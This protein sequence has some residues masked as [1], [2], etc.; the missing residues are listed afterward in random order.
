GSRPTARRSTYTDT[1]WTVASFAA[2]RRGAARQW[3]RGVPPS[4]RRQDDRRRRGASG[5]AGWRSP[6]SVAAMAD[7]R[8]DLRCD[9]RPEAARNQL[10]DR[11]RS[12]YGDHLPAAAGGLLDHRPV[13]RDHRQACQVGAR[14]D[15]E[16]AAVGPGVLPRADLRRHDYLPTLAV[17]LEAERRAW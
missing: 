9:R 11:R 7:E 4:S 8:R 15:R 13:R 5:T 3:A 6:R 12:A 10:A 2:G 17:G 14:D 1:T 16:C